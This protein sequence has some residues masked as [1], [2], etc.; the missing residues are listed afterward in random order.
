LLIDKALLV[1]FVKFY[2]SEF[3]PI[4]F[5]MF[6]NQLENYIIDMRMSDEFASMKKSK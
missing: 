4:N 2:P 6:N 3:W 5:M 1:E